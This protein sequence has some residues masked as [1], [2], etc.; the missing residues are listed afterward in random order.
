MNPALASIYARLRPVKCKGLCTES[1]GP[2]GMHPVEVE[3]VRVK[4][5]R[6]PVVDKALVCS[7]LRDGPCAARSAASPQ[8]PSSPTP[9]LKPCTTN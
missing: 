8:A 9:R 3:N 7:E 5:G 1:C 2:I 6:L 4:Y